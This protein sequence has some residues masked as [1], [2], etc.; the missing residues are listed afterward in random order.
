[1]R[2]GAR[3]PVSAV[4]WSVGAAVRRYT[5]DIPED[6]LGGERYMTVCSAAACPPSYPWLETEETNTCGGALPCADCSP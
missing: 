5:V 1:M 4:V 3:L 6:G 2:R